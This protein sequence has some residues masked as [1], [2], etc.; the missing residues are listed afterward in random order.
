MK[1]MD[2]AHKYHNN[3]HTKFQT[4]KIQIMALKAFRKR[5]LQN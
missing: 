3:S 5:Q 4:D 1:F 2:L